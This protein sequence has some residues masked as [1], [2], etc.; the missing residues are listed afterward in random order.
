MI[1]KLLFL[2]ATEQS[3][4]RHGPAVGTTHAACVSGRARRYYQTEV[5]K[6]G[7][8][9]PLFFSEGGEKNGDFRQSNGAAPADPEDAARCLFCFVNW[10]CFAFC[11]A[12]GIFYHGRT[13]AVTGRNMTQERHARG[14]VE[15]L[16]QLLLFIGG[17]SCGSGC[18]HICD[19]I[20]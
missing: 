13:N 6:R 14:T 3:K 11:G 19:T 12:G 16:P 18:C 15:P 10:L 9:G 1:V 20:Y 17:I 8:R 5:K 7:R 2:R 4:R